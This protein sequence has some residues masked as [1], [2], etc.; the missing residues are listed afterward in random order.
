MSLRSSLWRTLAGLSFVLLTALLLVGPAVAKSS[1]AKNDRDRMPNGWEKK[2]GL[3]V[4]VNDAHEDPDGDLLKN[5]AEFRNKTDPQDPDSDDDGF[6][7]G[8]EVLEGTDPT[9]PEDN[10]LADEEEGGE[11]ADAGGDEA[12]EEGDDEE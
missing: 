7:D 6:T 2:H 3:N 8:D 12:D 11:G 4:R 10:L 1:N 5:I 9:D